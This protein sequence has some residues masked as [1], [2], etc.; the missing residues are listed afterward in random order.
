MA[1]PVF[2]SALMLLLI[3]RLAVEACVTHHIREQTH[4]EGALLHQDLFVDLNLSVLAIA[5]INSSSHLI[6]GRLHPTLHNLKPFVEELSLLSTLSTTITPSLLS[7]YFPLTKQQ[8]YTSYQLKN[9][10]SI[11][12]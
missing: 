1:N 4:L 11:H 9:K 2:I 8:I 5:G 10:D 3:G 7:C 6:C 12:R